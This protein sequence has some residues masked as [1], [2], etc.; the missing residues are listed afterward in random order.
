MILPLLIS[1]LVFA[2]SLYV[3]IEVSNYFTDAAERI[4]P[5]VFYALYIGGLFK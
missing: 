3:L 5:L 4:G 2:A 1:M